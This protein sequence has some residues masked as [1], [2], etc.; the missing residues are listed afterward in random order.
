M[1][2]TPQHDK[3]YTIRYVGMM[4]RLRWGK[5]TKTVQKMLQRTRMEPAEETIPTLHKWGETPPGT[6]ALLPEDTSAEVRIG[7]APTPNLPKGITW[8]LTRDDNK[9]SAN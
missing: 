6:L 8:I 3:I 2:N 5:E 7:V 4:V 9:K 1:V